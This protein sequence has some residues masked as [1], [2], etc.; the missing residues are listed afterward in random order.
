MI[1]LTYVE[2][3]L[4]KKGKLLTYIPHRTPYS[5]D[6]SHPTSLLHLVYAKAD[7]SYLCSI[8]KLYALRELLNLCKYIGVFCHWTKAPD[9][10]YK[11]IIKP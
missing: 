8:K 11:K 9:S 5:T 3:H 4:L 1:L 6:A 7:T 2:E 10:L